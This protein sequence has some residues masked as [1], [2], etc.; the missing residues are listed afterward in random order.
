MLCTNMI[1]RL[2]HARTRRAQLITLLSRVDPVRALEVETLLESAATTATVTSGATSAAG[3]GGD[4]AALF[5]RLYSQ[6]GI[7]SSAQLRGLLGGMPPLFDLSGESVLLCNGGSSST[8][9]SDVLQSSATATPKRISSS[10][11]SKELDLQQSV[12]AQLLQR[13]GTVSRMGS[14]AAAAASDGRTVYTGG[15]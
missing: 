3:G 11:G 1:H 7:S 14:G 10:S 6:Y 2:V 5:A 8:S 13:N 15:K 4:Y 12:D 9:S